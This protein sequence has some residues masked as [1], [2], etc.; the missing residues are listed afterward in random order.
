[1][2]V[3]NF[4]GNAM[5]LLVMRTNILHMSCA[6]KNL[7]DDGMQSF[8]TARMSVH[9]LFLKQCDKL[10]VVGVGSLSRLTRVQHL[11]I[12]GCHNVMNKRL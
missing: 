3:Q 1:M 5:Q 7:T 9:S 8:G 2:A 12:G 10:T 11:H 4:T 6:A